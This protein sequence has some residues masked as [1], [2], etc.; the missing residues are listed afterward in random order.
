[1]T[2]PRA[3]GSPETG[4]MDAA[5]VAPEGAEQGQGTALAAPAMEGALLVEKDEL[6]VMRRLEYFWSVD[7]TR[8]DRRKARYRRVKYWRAGIRNVY[9]TTSEAG[10][11]EVYAPP[12]QA[13][14]PPVPNLVDRL[15]RRVTAQLLADPMQPDVVPTNGDEE[16]EAHAEFA[17]KLLRVEH[18]ESG[19]NFRSKLEALSDMAHTFASAFAY[20][21]VDPTGGGWEPMDVW[22]H[23]NATTLAEV[24]AGGDPQPPTVPQ[25][26]VD[27]MTGQPMLGPDGQ[28]AMQ[29]APN[30]RFLGP[31]AP[32]V[33]RYVM[34]DGRL[35]DEPKEDGVECKR[36][37][38]P[39]NRWSL[40]PSANVRFVPHTTVGGLN[41][42]DGVVLCVPA[43]LGELKAK[44][45]ELAKLEPEEL[46]AIVAYRPPKFS[47]LKKLQDQPEPKIQRSQ[48]ENGAP[49][50]D[51]V[52]YPLTFYHKSSAAY[53]KGAYIVG[54]GKKILHRQE[55]AVDTD[56]G[57]ELLDIPL[58]QCRDFDAT[59]EGDPYGT[60]L[61]E[62]LGPLD[63]IHA[64]SWNFLLEY[65]LKHGSPNVFI[66]VTSPVQPEQIR[67][68]DG[69]VIAVT[70][71]D[72]MPVYETIPALPP[73]IADMTGRIAAEL[74]SE[75]GLEQA[76]QGVAS[77]GVN[78]GVHAEQIIEQ[79]L[80]ALGQMKRNLDDCAVR[81]WRV[82]LQ[83]KRAFWTTPQKLA[84]ES[85]DGSWREEEWSSLD[86]RT[87]KHVQIARGTST[88][89]TRSAKA[90]I[91]LQ[92]LQIGA[93]SL[94]EYQ[95]VMNSGVSTIFGRIDNPHKQR[96]M[97]QI[98]AWKEGP[99]EEAKADPMRMQQESMALFA[100]IMA[101]ED[102]QGAGIRYMEL[103]KLQASTAYT[104]QPPEWR[105]GVD[106]ALM[107][108]RHAAGIMTVAEQ[109]QMQ[110]AQ[111][112]AQMQQQ[113]AQQQAEAEKSDKSHAQQM[114][115][116][117]QQN[118]AKAATEQQRAEAQQA[119]AAMRNP[120]P[121]MQ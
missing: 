34:P 78:S 111:Q 121:M 119:A 7:D 68:R 32:P 69:S 47:D 40:L 113:Q 18:S 118:D 24:E 12:S 13:I 71:K 48:N 43:T 30:P 75:S 66:P 42:C 6:K 72:D 62:Y 98:V 79:A 9:L 87:A 28:P 61:G 1:M 21:T 70:S 116:D 120:Q 31:N 83:L 54:V 29:D 97:R 14:L 74:N 11:V 52:C 103:V 22:A 76:A 5:P 49:E 64:Q 99:S 114:E 92:E 41:E 67:R 90:G 88:M 27:P 107:A 38:L 89:M 15:C 56:D 25:P 100:P 35:A 81:M 10:E 51:A 117:A 59:A 3:F 94:P 86:I 23:P 44:F 95:Q 80:V 36:R 112:Q 110:A 20:A 57:L 109:Q 101:D 85:E 115:R 106:Q 8:M 82:D 46:R 63:E 26:M 17:T 50:D 102:Q 58:A 60:A 91:A 93:I 16:H 65:M 104:K 77:P 37:W 108:A 73:A 84:Y 19:T 2:A 45:P 39:K 96:I 33:R 53:P 4:A 55:W 105:V